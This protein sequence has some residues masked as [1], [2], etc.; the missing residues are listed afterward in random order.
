V[1]FLDKSQLEKSKAKL[2]KILARMDL[3]SLVLIKLQL[4]K[5]RKV[6]LKNHRAYLARWLGKAW[7][8]YQNQRLLPQPSLVRR[9]MINPNLQLV[10]L[11]PRPQISK[12]RRLPQPRNQRKQMAALLLLI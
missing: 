12:R 9:Q 2:K 11:A 4:L 5:I 3:V 1:G 6:K 8:D 10:F 7:Q